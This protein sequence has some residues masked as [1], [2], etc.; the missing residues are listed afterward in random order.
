MWHI[1]ENK[2]KNIE[3]FGYLIFEVPV[4]LFVFFI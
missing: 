3:T 2:Y 4:E 1:F